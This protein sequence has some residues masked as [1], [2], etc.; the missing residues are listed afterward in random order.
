MPQPEPG[1]PQH[2]NGREQH[3]SLMYRPAPPKGRG[4][5]HQ[6]EEDQ[7]GGQHARQAGHGAGSEP[8]R[9]VALDRQKRD[10][11][12]RDRRRDRQSQPQKTRPHVN[13]IASGPDQAGLQHE[14]QHPAE[15]QGAVQMNHR[16]RLEVA[17]RHRR[18]IGPR[19]AQQDHRQP[20]QGHADIKAAVRDGA[21]LHARHSLSPAFTPNNDS[22]NPAMGSPP[23]THRR[24]HGL[25]PTSC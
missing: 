12:R 3:Q 25:C 17:V 16:R 24:G 9:Q 5:Q 1:R 2:D 18:E 7:H 4:R 15:R 19:E 10:R 6:A 23:L 11:N 13:V 21:G 8:R 20:G 22:R 14:Q